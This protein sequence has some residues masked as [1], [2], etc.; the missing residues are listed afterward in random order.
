MLQL[1]DPTNETKPIQRPRNRRPTTLDRATIGLLD[2]AKM[3]GDLFLD[4][5]DRQFTQ[6]GMTVKRYQKPTYAHPAPV[7]LQQQIA[8]EC[9][10]VLE[11]LAD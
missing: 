5:L 9:D 1:L 11:A 4:E 2:I 6:R 7:H 10:V 3:R 8:T